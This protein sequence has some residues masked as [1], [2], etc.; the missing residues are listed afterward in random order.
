M[1][2]RRI[3]KDLAALIKKTWPDGIVE[4]FS[5]T[6]S[7]FR[8]IQ[9]RLQSRLLA[10]PGVS[11]FWQTPE[12]SWDDDCAP[13]DLPWVEFQSFH[14]YFLA[15]HGEQF[16]LEDETEGLKDPDDPNEEGWVETTYPGERWI[17]CG[18]DIC[19]AA[20]V[21]IL[22]FAQYSSYEDGSER[23]PDVT[24][25]DTE[26]YFRDT[27]GEKAFQKLEELCAKIAPILGSY[28]IRILDD[29][30]L[31]LTVPGLK[32]SEEVFMEEPVHV[33]EA[34]FFRGV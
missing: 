29:S 17:G 33:Y 6:D 15:P 23:T 3:P 9:S 10:I 28:R 30:V 19:M 24:S 1:P 31:G 8:G 21:A 26:H 22:G 27:L 2:T 13:E 11:M 18:L 4:Q 14:Q 34:F 5:D 25:V 12:P 7:Y 16:Q 32:A 20:R